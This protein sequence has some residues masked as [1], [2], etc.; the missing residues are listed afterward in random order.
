M[1]VKI[2]TITH[3]HF[4]PPPDPMY[5][6]LHVGHACGL[7]LGYLGDDSGDHISLKNPYF[8]E[9]TGMYWL[10]K[11]K[12]AA[13]YIG[14]CH[15][16]RYLINDMGLLFTEPELERLFEDYDMI[17]TKMLTLT[18][19]YYEGFGENHYLKDLILTG[20]VLK[21]KYPAYYDTYVRMVHDTHTY[22]GN[23]FITTRA[24]YD[25]YCSWLFDILFELEKR[26]DISR[27]D[28]YN[29]RLFG[30]V[31]EFLQTV[32]IEV[33]QLKVFECMVGMTGEKFETRQLRR[34]LAEFFARGDFAGAQKCFLQCYEKRP[35][36]LMEASDVTG[37]LRLCMQ[38]I[39]TCSYEYSETGHC[40]LEKMK[41]YDALIRH[42][43]RVNYLI[44]RVTDGTADEADKT[45]LTCTD[46][47]S[48]SIRVALKLFCDNESQAESLYSALRK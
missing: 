9:L 22:F 35:D 7:D 18:C 19:T 34:E 32:W 43:H 40:I 42:F 14:I 24:D 44:K 26:V 38:I 25:R 29:K 36:I 37:E 6:P 2:F 12:I 3:K 23:I 39:S 17:T 5:T 33:N 13:D 45:A 30:F 27:Y 41:D 11:N 20:E 46:L 31:S 16:R 21:E 8:C 10:W 1:S 15:Y 4:T 28:D 47:S 48:A